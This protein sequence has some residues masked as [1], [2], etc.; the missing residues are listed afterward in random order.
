M[1]LNLSAFIEQFE[2]EAIEKGL[3]RKQLGRSEIIFLEQVWGPAFQYQFDGLKAEHPFKDAK[4]G[5]RFADFVYVKNG[6]RMLIE[7][8]GFTTHARDISPG[9]F[10]DHLTRQND[11]ILS[12]WLVLRFSA[13]QV[14]KRPQVCARQLKQAIGHWWSL[15]YGG[16]SAGE[17]DSWRLR[18]NHIAQMAMR[19]NGKIKPGEVAAEFNISNHTAGIWL[20]RFAKEGSFSVVPNQM[21]STVYLLTDFAP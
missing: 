14:E 11:L 17:I 5:Q 7:V 8:D 20:K 3:Y 19:R 1:N 12:G 13:H 16:Y 18:K 6:I 21:R 4:G 15:T 10:D 2:R 9:E